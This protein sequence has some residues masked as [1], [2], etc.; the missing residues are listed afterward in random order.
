MIAATARDSGRRSVSAAGHGAET[1]PLTSHEDA[2]ASPGK[3][4]GWE[5]A[6]VPLNR[7]ERRWQLI[8]RHSPTLQ[9]ARLF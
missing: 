3:A 1:N 4:T 5:P 6:V 7:E 8:L 2:P 9:P